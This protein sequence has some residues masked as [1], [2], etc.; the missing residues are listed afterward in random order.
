MSITRV[1]FS[2]FSSSGDISCF[3]V[4]ILDDNVL[5]GEESVEISISSEDVH[6][7]PKNLMLIIQDESNLNGK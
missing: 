5:E 3:E 4:M 7:E 1:L 6:V 2:E